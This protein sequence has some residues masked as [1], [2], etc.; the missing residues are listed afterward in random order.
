LDHT[1]TAEQH[2]Y[3][4]SDSSATFHSRHVAAR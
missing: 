3:Q 4:A 1:R 2:I